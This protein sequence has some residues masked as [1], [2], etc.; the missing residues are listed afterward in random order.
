MKLETM[1]PT[2]EVEISEIDATLDEVILYIQKR[3]GRRWKFNRTE[4]RYESCIMA[5]FEEV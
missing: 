5:I 2:L 1:N 3:Y 4:P